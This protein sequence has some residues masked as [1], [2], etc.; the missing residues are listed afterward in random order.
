MFTIIFNWSFPLT[1]QTPKLSMLGV[2]GEASKLST[3]KNKTIKLFLLA[4]EKNFLD[5]RKLLGE[6]SAVLKIKSRALFPFC[7]PG[8]GWPWLAWC[9]LV[10]IQSVSRNS[11]DMFSLD[12]ER[13][14][15]FLFTETVFSS[16]TFLLGTLMTWG[17]KKSHKAPGLR[18]SPSAGT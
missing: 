6:L 11:C 8:P 5:V 2:S 18:E 15:Q 1:Q 13:D 14:R 3:I 10:G 4:L 16:V 9:C 7:L 12:M 17:L